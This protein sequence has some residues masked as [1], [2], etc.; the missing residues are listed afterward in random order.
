MPRIECI[1][2]RTLMMKWLARG[3]ACAD[4]QCTFPP[5][6][7]LQHIPQIRKLGSPKLQCPF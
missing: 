7:A 6:V 3:R 2:V 4:A 5:T 1:V